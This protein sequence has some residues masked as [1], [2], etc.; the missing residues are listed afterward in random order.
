MLSL[1]RDIESIPGETWAT[2][3]DYPKYQI[4]SLG[5]VKSLFYKRTRV[6]R[7]LKQQFINYGYLRVELNKKGNRFFVHR[8]VAKAFI[9]NTENKPFINHKNGVKT[10]NCVSNLEWCTNSE[11]VK[12]AYSILGK[13]NN[14]R[15]LNHERG[16]LNPK[17]RKVIQFDL[18][19]NKLSDY[20]SI[21]DAEI[22]TG[23]G[24]SRIVAACKG[25]YKTAG[26]FKWKYL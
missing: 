24:N 11:N 3:E 1:N 25:R 20:G 9:P 10:D 4:S 12:H 15:F 13:E 6:S 18:S 8:L 16:H 23:I 7:I 26:G 21:R 14:A 5:R 19:N 17:A 22:A 2:I